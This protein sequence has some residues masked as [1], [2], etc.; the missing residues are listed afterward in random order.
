MKY[1]TENL[2]IRSIRAVSTPAQ[3]QAEL[4]LSENAARTTLE[5]RREIQQLL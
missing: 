4:P 1:V 3:V 2:R 5:A